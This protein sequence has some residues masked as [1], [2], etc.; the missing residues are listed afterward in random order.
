MNSTCM[1]IMCYLKVSF[2]AG[3]C[4]LS[5]LLDK[6]KRSIQEDQILTNFHLK[7]L[8]LVQTR[9]TALLGLLVSSTFLPFKMK[10][11]VKGLENLFWLGRHM[12]TSL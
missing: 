9:I 1:F 12:F 10:K 6:I 3:G 5:D 4:R 7:K 8:T 2:V 11:F